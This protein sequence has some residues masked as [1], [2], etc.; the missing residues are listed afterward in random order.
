MLTVLQPQ[1]APENEELVRGAVRQ[2]H[3]QAISITE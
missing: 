2:C 3:R 1:V